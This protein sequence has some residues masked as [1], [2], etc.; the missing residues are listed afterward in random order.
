MNRYDKA[1]QL[2]YATQE[3][4]SY[5]NDMERL[6]DKNDTNDYLLLYFTGIAV[7]IFVS[8]M[9]VMASV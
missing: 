7:G 4:I 6:Q 8:C 3:F 2:E 5:E 9:W 1:L